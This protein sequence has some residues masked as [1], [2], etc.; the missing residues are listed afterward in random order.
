[1]DPETQ[2]AGMDMEAAVADIAD[3]LALTPQEEEGAPPEETGSGEEAVVGTEPEK[4]VAAPVA[5]AAAPTPALE[6]GDTAPDTW[7]KEAKEAW[8]TVPPVV[9]EELKK[10]ESDIAQYVERVK[11]PVAVGEK[12]NGIIAPYLPMFEKTGVDPWHNIGAMLKA[13]ELLLFGSPEQKLAMFGSLA[14]QAGLKFENGALAAPPDATAQY[15][16]RLED[17]LRQLEGG[18]QKV[19]STVQ[20]AQQ[21][22]L[23]Q[24]VAAFAQDPSHPFFYDV[25][26]KIEHL[27]RGGAAG[28]LEEAYQ[29]AIMADPL[30]RQKVVEGEATRVADAKAKADK[31]KLAKAAKASR[32]NVRS[33]SRA[34]TVQPSSTIDDTLKDTLAEINAR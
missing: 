10:R 1:M 4:E 27:I 6:A 21:A 24:N 33:T 7:R 9:R 25:T 34:R 23:Q 20:E 26:D 11:A 12:L 29:M 31:E 22:E 15:V 28:N 3:A 17:R 30:I 13:Q 8:A 5:P 19:T 16:S 32:V 2:E 18:V 14:Q